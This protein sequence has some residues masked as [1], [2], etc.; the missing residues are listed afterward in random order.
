MRKT[1]WR[2]FFVVEDMLHP[3]IL[4]VWGLDT[5]PGVIFFKISAHSAL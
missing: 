2:R 1:Y 4:L 3:H 5:N